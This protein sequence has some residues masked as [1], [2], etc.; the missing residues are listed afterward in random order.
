MSEITI[1]LL[2]K[3]HDR[4]GF[5]CG[6]DALDRYLQTQS[7]QDSKR[8]TT[9]VFVATV[10][11]KVVGFY[12]LSATVLAREGLP[13]D[14]QKKL[15]KYPIPGILLGR[16]AVTKSHQNQKL[17]AHLLVNA[18]R[19]AFQAS[20]SIGVYAL[21]VDAKHDQA[22]AFYRKFGFIPFKDHPNR[23]FLPMETIASLYHE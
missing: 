20:Q 23:L 5:E 2:A 12:T 7:T 16:L 22:K 17:G 15:P 4:S 19:R 8:R 18:M 6:E 3:H 14:V 10:E 1:E 9:R 21:V 11:N 13:E